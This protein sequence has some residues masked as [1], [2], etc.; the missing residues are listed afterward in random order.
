MQTVS[1][2]EYASG[3]T[4]GTHA[5]E[6]RIVIRAITIDE[7]MVLAV[8]IQLVGRYYSIYSTR[9]RYRKSRDYTGLGLSARL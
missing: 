3:K 8:I 1:Y 6:T 2:A 4:I 5:A 7:C 9:L